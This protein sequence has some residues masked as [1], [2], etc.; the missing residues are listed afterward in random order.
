MT[1]RALIGELVIA[2]RPII[3]DAPTPAR[4]IHRRLGCWALTSV[5]HAL[6][7]M[8]RT[9]EVIR[10]SENTVQGGIRWLYRRAA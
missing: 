8:A 4:D 5:K 2:L 7:A 10:E 1:D 6:N 9:G 3:P